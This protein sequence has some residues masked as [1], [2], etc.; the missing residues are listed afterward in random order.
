MPSPFTDSE[1]AFGLWAENASLLDG[2]LGN[3]NYD[4]GHVFAAECTGGVAG[5][6]SLA[7][8]CSMKNKAR[9]VSCVF[10]GNLGTLRATFYHEIGHQLGA[11]HTWSNCGVAVNEGQRSAVTA[12]EPGSG[13]TIMSYGGVCGPFNIVASAQSNLHGISIQEVKST[14]M[15][16]TINCYQLIPTENTPPTVNVRESG[17]TIPIGTPFEL[18]AIAADVDSTTLTYSWEQFDTGAVSQIG[19]PIANAPSFRAYTP[20]RESERIFPRINDIILNRSSDVEVLPDTT[21]RLTFGVTVRDN[22]ERGGSTT[23]SEVL[24]FATAEAGPFILTQPDSADIEYAPADSIMVRWE[25]AN[26][27]VAP[28]NCSLVDVFLTV[29]NGKTFDHVLA[30]GIANNGETKVLLPDTTT[31]RARIKVKCADN[32]FFDVSN[33]R[34]RIVEQ[35]ISSTEQVYTQP[36]DLFPNPTKNKVT[37]VFSEKINEQID[38]VIIDGLGQIIKRE[39]VAPFTTDFT[40]STNTLTNGIYYIKGN[41]RDQFFSKRFIKNE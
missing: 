2:L 9:A 15:S 5:L 20:I 40:I 21:R 34:F 41:I 26:T 39:T 29:D 16:D 31:T 28:V 27:D 22:D 24:F 11:N 8:V 37:I 10:G 4:L 7:N 12:V 33:N 36:I 35:I 18:N 30:K 23:F 17:F 13:S 14:L 3:D 19:F 25:V 38:L 32:I 6:A 1:D